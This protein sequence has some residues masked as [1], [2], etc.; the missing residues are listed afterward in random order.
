MPEIKVD[1]IRANVKRGSQ[2]EALVDVRVDGVLLIGG[3]LLSF[4]EEKTD[5]QI[6][7]AAITQ[8]YIPT[9]EQ[10]EQEVIE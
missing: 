2:H 4:S 3:A 7:D 5:D 1:I 6:T 8:I 9:I 10:L